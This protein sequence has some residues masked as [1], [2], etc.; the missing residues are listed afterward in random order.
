MHG[1]IVSYNVKVKENLGLLLKNNF[2]IA[3][4]K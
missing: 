1:K 3:V 2:Y 4:N